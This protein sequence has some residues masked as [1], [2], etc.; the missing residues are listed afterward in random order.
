MCR[1]LLPCLAFGLSLASAAEPISLGSRRELFVD[2]LLIDQMEGATLRLHHPES[3]GSAVKFDQPWEGRFSAYITVIH[4]DEAKKYQMYYR[5]N[6]GFKDGT[7]GEVTCYAESADGKTWVKPKLGLHEINGSKDNNVMLANLAPYTHNFA[8]FIDKRPGVPKEQ[9]YKAL[10]GLGGKYGGLSAFVSADGLHWQKMQEKAVITK[11]AFDS[12]NVSF[13]SEAEQCYVAYFRVF[14]GGGVDEKTWKPKGVRWVSRATSKD[15]LTWTD[16]VQMTCDQPLVDHIY[17]SQ[18]NPYF[19]APHHYI[20]TAARYMPGKAV[21]DEE[22]KKELAADTKAYPA[23]IKDCSEAVLMTS[24]AGT[25][26]YNRS[27]ME[28][29]VRPGSDLHNWTSRSNYPACGVVRTGPA[30]M[31]LFVERS[32]GQT[33]AWLERLTLR[34]DG[35]ASL[36]ADYAEAAMV[37]KP[38]TF[39]GKA[40]HLNLSTGAAGSVAVEILDAAGKPLPGFTLADCQAVSYDSIDRVIAWKAG[41]DVS[42]LAGKPVRLRWVLRDADVFSFRFE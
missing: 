20:S 13:W 41:S 5:G 26:A 25:T 23:L 9:R 42:A 15:F 24:R 30:E 2:K 36:H 19:N 18:T 33:A 32:Y 39:T 14:T 7:T 11:G 12:Q 17:I 4:N 29:F 27:F 31:S 21:L 38:F 10:A 16:A 22:T 28:G 3:A 6:A 40:L 35:F 34:V 37:T 1:T 8:P